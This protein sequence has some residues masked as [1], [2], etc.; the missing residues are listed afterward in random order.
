MKF[1]KENEFKEWH[2]YLKAY[3]WKD[4]KKKI[5]FL[6]QNCERLSTE[7][8]HSVQKALEEVEWTLNE[9]VVQELLREEDVEASVEKYLENSRKRV[10]DSV[11]RKIK[12]MVISRY[13]PQPGQEY[14]LH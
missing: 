6:I 5:L 2:D 1:I 7:S 3:W 12:Q 8:V 4:E 14:T 10:L 9:E 11:Q 13:A